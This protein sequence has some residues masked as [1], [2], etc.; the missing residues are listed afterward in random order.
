MI[1]VISH[2]W[3]ERFNFAFQVQNSLANFFF[4]ET[5]WLVN[6]IQVCCKV[7]SFLI[8]SFNFV[9]YFLL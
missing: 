1:P 3:R 6:N 5:V 9:G 7:I 2:I 8:F 4:D